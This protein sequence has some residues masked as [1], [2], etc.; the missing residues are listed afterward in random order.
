MAGV[1]MMEILGKTATLEW[2]AILDPLDLMAGQEMMV[3]LER[4]EIQVQM[5]D[6]DL[7]EIPDKMETQGPMG[8]L[9][10]MVTLEVLGTMDDLDRMEILEKTANQ[11][12]MD[13]LDQMAIQDPQV[14]M[15]GQGTMEIQ[16]KMG[17]P[18]QMGDLVSCIQLYKWDNL[19]ERF[20]S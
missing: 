5:G 18:E 4:M 6:P 9:E 8:D 10:M 12:M 2:M 11:G 20:V 1:E 14:Q 19:Q 3:I 17:T 7:M 13:S 15:A 16:D